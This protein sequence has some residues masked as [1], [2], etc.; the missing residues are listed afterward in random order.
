MQVQRYKE[1]SNELTIPHQ[2]HGQCKTIYAYNMKCTNLRSRVA[3]RARYE[4]FDY[5]H[6]LYP[7]NSDVCAWEMSIHPARVITVLYPTFCATREPKYS[8][9]ASGGEGVG[10]G[11]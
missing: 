10:E 7:S 11:A 8:E 4:A 2:G 3:E 5:S 6:S 1:L 9:F